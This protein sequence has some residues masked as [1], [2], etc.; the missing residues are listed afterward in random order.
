MQALEMNVPG[1]LNCSG[2]GNLESTCLCKF[3]WNLLLAYTYLGVFCVCYFRKRSL[4]LYLLYTSCKLTLVYIL[5]QYIEKVSFRKKYQVFFSE[6]C[7]K[8]FCVYIS[9]VSSTKRAH[10]DQQTAAEWAGVPRANTAPSRT[11]GARSPSSHENHDGNPILPTSGT[12]ARFYK[13]RDL[14]QYCTRT[15]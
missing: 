11:P 1:F 7:E 4:H 12:E 3:D 9:S 15:G 5:A 13:L 14:C 6:K 2:N 10:I 8:I